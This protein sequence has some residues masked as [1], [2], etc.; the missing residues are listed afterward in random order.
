MPCTVEAKARPTTDTCGW[1]KQWQDKSGGG[2][3]KVSK[4]NVGSMLG[5]S[6]KIVE[7]LARRTVDI[8]CI[9]EVQYKGEGCKMFSCEAQCYNSGGQEKRGRKE[10]VWEYW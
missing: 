3:L 10:E 5:R 4:M 8:C 7:M 1:C 6:R 9:Q 2:E